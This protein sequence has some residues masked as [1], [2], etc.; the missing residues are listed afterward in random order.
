MYPKRLILDDARHFGIAVLGL[1][2][3][4][5]RDTY[6]VEHVADSKWGIR[7]PFTEVSGVS[8]AEVER[9]MEAQPFADLSDTWNRA[10]LSRPVAESLVVAG[11]FDALH[12]LGQASAAR[13]R[14]INRRDLLLQIADLDRYR[15]SSAG[16]PP[17][18]LSLDLTDHVAA[19]V[20]AGL[21]EMDP[22]ERV[23]AEVQ[24][25][26]LDISAHVIDFYAD[27]LDAIG[28]TKATDLLNGRSRRQVFIGGVKVAVQTPPVRSGRRVIFLTLDDSTGPVDA[29]FFEDAQ[30]PYAQTVFSS[31]LLLI[32]GE[33][34]RTGP[35]G[36]SVLY[37]LL[38]V[39][40]L[41]QA[42]AGGGD[43]CVAC[44]MGR[45]PV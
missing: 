10:G 19:N 15:R 7:V 14:R 31:W 12:S 21:P 22:A 20:P 40:C 33:L 36:V 24:V 8:S 4:A 39:R 17:A 28:T 38:G 44:V 41:T 18:Q 5:S 11:A 13:S 30:G 43:R 3:N 25:T 45:K 6:R 34:R 2:V 37:R 1:D 26:G 9:L 27:L 32:R 29:A 16:L 42:L 35:R 23:R